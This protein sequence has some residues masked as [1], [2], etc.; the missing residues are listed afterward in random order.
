MRKYQNVE[1]IFFYQK[2]LCTHKQGQY[3]IHLCFMRKMFVSFI[4]K[5]HFFMTPNKKYLQLA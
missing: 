5:D 2:F 1:S 4:F 3:G